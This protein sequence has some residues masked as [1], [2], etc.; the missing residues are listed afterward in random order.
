MAERCEKP[1]QFFAPCP[2]GLE[3]LLAQ[4]LA[5]LGAGGIKAADGGVHFA[6]SLPLAWRA[7]LESRIASRV[8][9]RVGAARYRHEDDIYR[10]ALGLDWSRW[11][12][13][14]QTL[15]VN[16]AATKSPLKSLDFATLR[17]K[18]AVCDAFRRACGRRPSVDT[19]A[20]D[21]RVHA[22]LSE[23][24]RAHV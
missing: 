4:E 17:V 18:D 13:V 14:D 5:A 21:V 24:G 1:H 23:I 20:P 3:P 6:G 9:W 16:L 15:R 22:Y 19:Q 10:I 12:D 8:L 7:N 2:R 11:F